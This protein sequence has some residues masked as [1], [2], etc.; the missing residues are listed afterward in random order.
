MCAQFNAGT[1]M[2]NATQEATTLNLQSWWRDIQGPIFIVSAAVD[3]FAFEN[4]CAQLTSDDVT[5]WKRGIADVVMQ[6]ARRPEVSYFVPDCFHHMMLTD[7]SVFTTLSAGITLSDALAAWSRGT[8]IHAPHP[9]RLVVQG[10]V[11]SLH[12]CG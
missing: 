3:R 7:E 10:N 6:V 9:S 11:T 12:L 5:S 2:W 8:T 1:A 4:A